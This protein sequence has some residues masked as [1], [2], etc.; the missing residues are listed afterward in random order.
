V[1]YDAVNRI[2]TFTPSANLAYGTTYTATITTGVLSFGEKH[3]A[4]DYTWHFTTGAAP[5]TTPPTVTTT[6]PADNAAGVAVNAAIT[7]TFSETLSAA[8]V[9]NSTFLLKNAGNNAVSGSVSYAGTTATITPSAPLAYGTSYA[10]T[11]T[12]GVQDLAGNYLASNY[13]WTF[14]TGSAPDTTPPVVSSVTPTNNAADVP[15]TSAVTADFS[16][17]MKGSTI[18]TTNF[19]VRN[20]RSNGIAGA[21]VYT[22]TTATFKPAANLDS[23]VTYSA[24]IGTGAQDLAGNG[25]ASDYT[26]T[27]RTA[28]SV[29]PRHAY[30]ANAGDNTVWTYIVHYTT[31]QLEYVG[32]TATGAWPTAVAVD[33]AGKY[34]Y[35][36]NWSDSTVSQYTIGSDGMLASMATTSVG[37]G[38]NPISMVVD[39]SGK[40]AYTAN[41]GGNGSISQY[42]IGNDGSLTYLGAKTLTALSM[43]GPSAI[44]IDPSGTYVYLTNRLTHTIEQFSIGADGLLT[45]LTP[46]TVAVGVGITTPVS[47]AVDP[48][49]THAYVLRYSDNL[50]SQYAIGPDG[51]LTHVDGGDLYVGSHSVFIT[52]DPSGRNAYFVTQGIN[53]S[54]VK[55]RAIGPDGLIAATGPL[56]AVSD[57]TTTSVTVDP[58]GRYLYEA[59]GGTNTIGQ[60]IIAPDGTFAAN[61]PA[62]VSIPGGA[63]RIVITSGSQLL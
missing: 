10:A 6:N 39:P 48:L 58:S 2:A 36:T 22:G 59:N 1:T 49:G 52:T 12:T 24:T 57:V 40:F 20:S 50:L 28:P 9:T 42:T 61:S 15:V 62:S 38:L 30:T 23:A 31:G 34:A 44:A 63:S 14:T 26:W 51:T 16:E 17:A 45:N 13:T 3:M 4:A 27:F 19:I 32:K 5:D 7:A 21:V 37:S 55:Q 43:S 47:I 35:V 41:N 18:T 8:T 33:P 53:A 29:Y 11:I 54:Y 56:A 25:L 60:Y 46:P